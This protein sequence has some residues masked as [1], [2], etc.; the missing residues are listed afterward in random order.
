M[1]RAEAV[2]RSS[3]GTQRPSGSDT[4]V[5]QTPEG[6]D[7]GEGVRF[8]AEEAQDLE[9]ASASFAAA[10]DDLVSGRLSEGSIIL[11]FSMLRVLL[12]LRAQQH[13]VVIDGLTIRN[14]L[15]VEHEISIDALNRLP[16]AMATPITVLDSARFDR[17]RAVVIVTDL[18]D[19]SGNTVVAAVHLSRRSGRYIVN[20]IASIHSK[21]QDPS[22]QRRIDAGLLRYVDKGKSLDWFTTRRLQLPKVVQT[23][24]GY[25]QSVLQESD[26]VKPESSQTETKEPEES[27]EAMNRSSAG[28][29]RPSGSDGILQQVTESVNKKGICFSMSAASDL[30]GADECRKTMQDVAARA[31][32]NARE[33][34]RHLATSFRTPLRYMGDVPVPRWQATHRRAR[35]LNETESG[36]FDKHSE[37]ITPYARRNRKEHIPQRLTSKSLL[38][39][40]SY[41]PGKETRVGARNSD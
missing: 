32:M 26:I 35:A 37:E 2:N 25:T 19:R 13:A 5:P 20:E 6:I 22:I 27:V 7:E 30:T 12:A 41:L 36:L 4:I 1:A 15:G 39:F 40:C 10:V 14:A 34:P 28:T 18:T 11:V 16:T 23:G 21:G 8:P 31:D 9:R 38:P 17:G 33:E 3:V 24:Q 29:H